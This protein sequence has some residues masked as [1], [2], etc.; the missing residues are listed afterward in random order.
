MRTLLLTL[1]V[2]LAFDG[3]VEAQASDNQTIMVIVPPVAKVKLVSAGALNFSLEFTAPNVAG[4]PIEAPGAPTDL[5]YLVYSS[6]NNTSGV[7]GYRTITV[8]TDEQPLDGYNFT[9]LPGAVASSGAGKKG[10][11]SGVI[12]LST[13]SRN[14]VT[15]IGS[16]YTGA[17][18]NNGHA[19]NYGV[20]VANGSAAYATLV[21]GSKA[22]RVIYTLSEN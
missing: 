3:L 20:S 14:I 4:E 1:V 5:T 8:K 10:V 19:L 18:V 11:A 7:G 6:I 16:S 17:A 9:V 2:L 22:F 21:A 12:T 13:T 15:A